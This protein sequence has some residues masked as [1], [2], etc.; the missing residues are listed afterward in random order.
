VGWFITLLTTLPAEAQ[1]AELEIELTQ[2]QGEQL[3]RPHWPPLWD[4][5]DALLS[6][7]RFCALKSIAFSFW[8]SANE[9]TPSLEDIITLM[10]LVSAK[11]AITLVDSFD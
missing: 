7:T 5:L 1:V 8:S 11:T 2:E 9:S 10:P 4:A 3:A 6:D